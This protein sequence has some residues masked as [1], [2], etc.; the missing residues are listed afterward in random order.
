MLMQSGNYWYNLHETES[1]PF[2]TFVTDKA[3]ADPKR[4][5][6]G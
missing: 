6:D 5:G 4:N 1:H 2:F 3:I